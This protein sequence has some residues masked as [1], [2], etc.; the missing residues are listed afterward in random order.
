M[1]PRNNL[2]DRIISASGKSSLAELH[3]LPL[4]ARTSQQLRRIL[5]HF[6]ICISQNHFVS[7]YRQNKHT[8]KFEV[9]Q[10]EKKVVGQNAKKHRQIAICIQALLLQ[11]L[12]LTFPSKGVKRW[13][14]M[15]SAGENII[16]QKIWLLRKIHAPHCQDYCT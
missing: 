3:S 8:N 4:H 9:Q 12:C 16:F 5:F 1:Q 10:K 2:P 13:Y 7:I 15:V 6:V 11:I 14:E